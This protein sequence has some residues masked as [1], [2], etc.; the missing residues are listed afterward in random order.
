MAACDSLIVTGLPVCHDPVSGCW[1]WTG[2]KDRNG[3]PVTAAHFGKA[4]HR[5]VYEQ[6]RGPVPEGLDLDHLCK[7]R[8]CVR[9]AHLEPVTR[10]DNNLRRGRRGSVR[11][12][13]QQHCKAGHTLFETGRRTP[14][15]GL[16][17][18]ACADPRE[19]PP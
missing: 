5:V 2:P 15:G 9:P 18:I 1:R 14:E 12:L 17:C 3:Y 13:R 10:A 8:D 11:R 16:I 4:A 19:K 7:R 6:L